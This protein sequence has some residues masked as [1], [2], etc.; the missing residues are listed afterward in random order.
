MYIYRIRAVRA[1]ILGGDMARI[2][3]VKPE[4]LRH[5]E[6]QLLE[7]ENPGKY[8]MFVF[9]GL[10]SVCDKRGV[11]P[12]RPLSLKLDIYPFLEFDMQETLCILLAGG[13][14]KKFK[15]A[16]NNFYGYVLNFEKHQRVTGIEASNPAKYPEPAEGLLNNGE[17]TIG[18]Q[19]RNN[20]ETI[21]KQPGHN[22]EILIDRERERE[23]EW[24]WEKEREVS[25]N[26]DELPSESLNQALELS[27]LLLTAH[28]KEI[29][30]YLSGKN[31]KNIT[32]Q[33]ARDI[34]KLI[35][36]DKKPPET[37][38]GVILWAKTP[39]CFW[40][41]HIVSGKKLREKYETLYS[42]MLEKG[43]PSA[44]KNGLPPG[45]KMIPKGLEAL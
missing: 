6:L 39:G 43:N 5:E 12:W 4:F 34:E 28:R 45:R 24:E 17:E 42:Q 19:L 3:T 2:R 29:P 18:K 26:S 32:S 38:R 37:I 21:G 14:I 23:W 25:G 9:M 7:K 36:L 31:N 27:E 22:E 40:F 41:P 30:D 8:P 10:W 16:D 44:A 33:W 13:F 11:F 35:R 20:E 1:G 15:A